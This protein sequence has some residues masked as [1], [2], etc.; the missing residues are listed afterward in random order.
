[1]GCQKIRKWSYAFVLP[2]KNISTFGLGKTNLIDTVSR[3][4]VSILLIKTQI[5]SMYSEL[6]PE[7]N[8]Y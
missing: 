7:L 2:S 4:N 6:E 5:M 1:M 8:V 3:Q